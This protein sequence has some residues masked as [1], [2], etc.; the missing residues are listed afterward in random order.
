MNHKKLWCCCCCIAILVIAAGTP[1]AAETAPQP[2]ALS[3]VLPENALVVIWAASP[4]QLMKS[5]GRFVPMLA[6]QLPQLAQEAVKIGLPADVVAS[7]VAFVVL[8][9]ADPA[10]DDEP[11]TALLISPKDQAAMLKTL[12]E[13]DEKGVYRME[14][15]SFSL[16][17]GF[18]AGAEDSGTLEALKGATKPYVPTTEAAKL[19]AKAQVFVHV[20]LPL[21][22]KTYAAQIQKGRQGFAD[23]FKKAMKQAKQ[24]PGANMMA[25][26]MSEK[27]VLQAFD[28][29]M[30]IAKEVES[31]DVAVSFD[32]EGLKVDAV[33]SAA[34]TGHI[35]RYLTA[36]GKADRPD[37][38]LPLLPQYAAAFWWQWDE[39]VQDMII[40]DA[41][42]VIDSVVKA[43]A[44]EN[45]DATVKSFKDIMEP[46]KGMMTGQVGMAMSMTADG[47]QLSEVIGVKKPNQFKP[48]MEKA[49]SFYNDLMATILATMPDNKMNI[50]YVYETNAK[51]IG[52]VS[53]D[54]VKTEMTTDTP[55]AQAALDKMMGIYGPDGLS[56]YLGTAGNN[57]VMCMGEGAT[58]QTL[59]LING[60]GG[61][62]VLNDDQAVKKARAKLAPQQHM[63]MLLVPARLC[64]F[65][66][67]MM[68]KMTGREAP[69]AMPFASPAAFGF[70]AIDKKNMA[71]EMYLPQSCISE[72]ITAFMPMMMGA[73]GGDQQID[74]GNGDDELQ[75][76]EGEDNGNDEGE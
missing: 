66:V 67:I 18:V 12:G 27:V 36:F 13:A 22:M 62:E 16:F 10:E 5:V 43:L 70:R 14:H 23:G 44:L 32:K 21:V 69:N 4:D 29:C 39:K 73:M 2:K 17:Q 33:T 7:P 3:A 49:F 30:S 54:R 9:P 56:Y 61:P 48:I 28:L 76:D 58:E 65:G 34:E 37:I 8:P 6:P 50:K 20:N 41:T 75:I 72:C 52:G 60:D 57:A 11:V 64:E 55:E 42:L 63:T 19:L 71:C 25:N 35:S 45:A 26:M 40:S 47:M 31:V 38:T 74:E 53:L 24:N 59:N 15:N 46:W 68:T 1:F 51:T